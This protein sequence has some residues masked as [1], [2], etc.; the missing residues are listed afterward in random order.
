MAAFVL[1]EAPP[2]NYYLATT[3]EGRGLDVFRDK[4]TEVGVA[5][6]H[7]LPRPF[8]GSFYSVIAFPITTDPATERI[9]GRIASPSLYFPQSPKK[10]SP[11]FTRIITWTLGRGLDSVH[12]PDI[13]TP[14]HTLLTLRP[15]LNLVTVWLPVRI[16]R[17]SITIVAATV[18]SRRSPRVIRRS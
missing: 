15:T 9:R 3:S 1:L 18:L 6:A 7:L 8:T 14:V 13:D 12:D 2:L 10:R 16:V 5:R 11:S 4:V 17:V